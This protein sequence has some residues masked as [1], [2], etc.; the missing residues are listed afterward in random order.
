VKIKEF[1]A[2]GEDK[3]TIKLLAPGN[4]LLRAFVDEN[5]NKKWDTGDFF[6]RKQPEKVYLYNKKLIIRSAWDTEEDWDMSK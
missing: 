2:T 3:L 4:Y 1:E 6:K 5:K